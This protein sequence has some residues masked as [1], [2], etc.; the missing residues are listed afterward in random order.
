MINIRLLFSFGLVALMQL[1]GFIVPAEL[2]PQQ[3]AI[4]FYYTELD[5]LRLDSGTSAASGGAVVW[6]NSGVFLASA[7]VFCENSSHGAQ[8]A[9][10]GVIGRHGNLSLDLELSGRHEVSVTVRYVTET[11]EGALTGRFTHDFSGSSL[12]LGVCEDENSG[13]SL[14][15]FN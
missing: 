3:Q 12:L 10:G 5:A 7:E 1:L 13:L 9:D 15:Q 4:D 11:D 8:R 14:V 6:N 2:L